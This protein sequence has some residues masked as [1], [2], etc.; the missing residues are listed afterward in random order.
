MKGKKDILTVKTEEI[1]QGILPSKGKNH[2]SG[3]K[4]ESNIDIH[5]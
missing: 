1:N 4:L 2:I 5:N 3:N